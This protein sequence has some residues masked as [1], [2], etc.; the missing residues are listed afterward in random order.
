MAAKFDRKRGGD[1]QYMFDLKAA[2]V[3]V[4]LTSELYNRRGAPNTASSR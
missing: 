1:E 3:E 2:N 4:I